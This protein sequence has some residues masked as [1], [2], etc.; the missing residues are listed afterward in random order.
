MELSWIYSILGTKQIFPYIKSTQ[1]RCPC[2]SLC[3]TPPHY[4]CFLTCPT[5]M[6][7]GSFWAIHTLLGCNHLGNLPWPLSWPC[8]TQFGNSEYVKSATQC[9]QL[10]SEWS[11]KKRSR[12]RVSFNYV[13]IQMK[14]TWQNINNYWITVVGMWVKYMVTF[15]QLCHIF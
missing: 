15:F 6:R 5:L 12:Y 3:N 7:K 9:L 13:C 8:K 14:Q 11:G 4:S 2:Y 10:A 1:C